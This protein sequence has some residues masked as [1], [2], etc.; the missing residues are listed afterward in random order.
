ML[1]SFFRIL[2]LVEYSQ[3]NEIKENHSYQKNNQIF[4]TQLS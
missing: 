2:D 3:M 4:S 1:N